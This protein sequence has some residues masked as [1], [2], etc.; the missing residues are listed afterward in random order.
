MAAFTV[1]NGPENITF[2]TSD[3][4]GAYENNKQV[5]DLNNSQLYCSSLPV[6]LRGIPVIDLRL[7]EF[8]VGN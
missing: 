6:F 5:R 7:L 2:I 4:S 8:F 3:E 1:S